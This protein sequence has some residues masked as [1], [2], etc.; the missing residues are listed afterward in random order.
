MARCQE[1]PQGYLNLDFKRIYRMGLIENSPNAIVDAANMA[2]TKLLRA[3]AIR[4]RQWGYLTIVSAIDA[5]ILYII[6]VGECPLEKAEKY[7][8]LSQEKARRLF[9]QIGVGRKSSWLSRNEKNDQWGGAICAGKVIV[10]FSG[11]SEL[12]DEAVSLM[13]AVFCGWLAIEQAREI[14]AISDNKF[15]EQLLQLMKA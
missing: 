2:I 15:F 6:Q 13:T 11:L 9:N 3:G 8:R 12:A 7:C 4:D 14:A 1:Y 10:S 5:R